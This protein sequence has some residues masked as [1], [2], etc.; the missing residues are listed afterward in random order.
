MELFELLGKISIDNSDANK[1][2]DETSG[3]G[4]NTES[5]LSKAFGAMGKGAVA[6]GKAVGGAMIAGGAAMG[7]LGV[8]ALNASGELE[9]NM[10]GA[11]QVFKDSFGQM[12]GTAKDAYKN[13]GLSQSDFLAT[14]NKMGALFQGAG[15][16][17]QESADLSSDAMQR[18]ADVASIMGIDTGAAMEAIAGA[19]KGNFSMMDNLGVAM[20]DTTLNAYAMEKGIK[21][22]TQEM[23]NQEKIGLAMEMFMEKTS[24]AAGNYAKENETLAGSLGTAKSA[25]NNFLSGAGDVED[26]VDSFGNLANV[27]VKNI[28]T[29]APRLVTGI[30]DIVNGILPMLP[31]LLN[32]VLPVLIDGAVNL[33]NGLVAALPSII[34][35]L[36]GALPA[37]IEGVTSIINALIEALPTIIESLVAALP[38]L[39]PAL[40]E[41][42]VS[43]I[44]TLCES[45]ADIIQP[46]IDYLPEI[47]VAIVD[48]L[49]TNA[50]ALIEGVV[51]LIGALVLAIPEILVAL[52][53]GISTAI[54]DWI[55]TL[56][57]WAS[58][59][60]DAIGG[61]W[62]GVKT[63]ASEKWSNIKTAV[64]DAAGNIKEKVGEK[65]TQLKD[66]A[67]TVWS[68]VKSTAST[69]WSN[70]KTA[71]TDKADSI[72][73]KASTAWTNLKTST[74]LA[75]SNIKTN[76]GTAWTGIKS[77]ISTAVSTAKNSVSNTWDTIKTKTSTVFS[78][79]KTSVST[80]WTGI[81]TAMT[82]PLNAA[83]TLIK[84]IVDKIKGFF[85]GLKIS[86]PSI[87]MPHFGITPKGWK[88]GDLLKGTIPKLGIDWYAKGGV[89]TKPTLF[90]YDPVSG[91][92]KVGG[93]AGAEA[94]A[95]IETLQQYIRTAVQGENAVMAQLLER[96]IELLTDFFPDAL[97]VMEQKLVLDTGVL[98]AETAPLMDREL[99]RIAVRKG[100]GR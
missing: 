28:K 71:I 40:V 39:I 52:W 47:I 84:N 72:K 65:F 37:L 18:A 74:S 82:T 87:K 20:N 46:I 1:A 13:M 100:R 41:G 61:W 85:T 6:V 48:A 42:L 9:Q 90:D 94:V 54:T 59:L 80:A 51:E 76:A 11:Q 92:A 7:T 34:E 32:S 55:G 57:D 75:W 38:D 44:V 81:K 31:G 16:S 93:E 24:Y 21:K 23:T 56:A 77:T 66:K 25:L 26:V 5:K 50:P 91:T 12:E 79:L 35:A 73:E 88:I 17:I 3:K 2:F 68:N 89:M 14:A 4:K 78:G 69:A 83:K 63:N 64:S 27:V 95:P 62:D 99:G 19:A 22:T 53:D 30:T 49:I 98:V 58:P 8:A 29:M 15:F 33:I 43:M 97:E 36:T 86:W 67:G 70:I 10:G 96:I 60:I 45:F